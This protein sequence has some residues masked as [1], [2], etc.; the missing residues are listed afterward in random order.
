MRLDKELESDRVDRIL[1]G[2]VDGRHCG[3]LCRLPG[4]GSSRKM[5]RSEL[6]CRYPG[7]RPCE[8]D[9]HDA[10][11]E[12]RLRAYVWESAESTVFFKV[13]QDV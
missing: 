5:K 13:K 3:E 1:P 7:T 9:R 10:D 2:F 4:V 6:I 12:F 8:V 11:V